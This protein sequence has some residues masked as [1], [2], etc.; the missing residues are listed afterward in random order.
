[1]IKKKNSR[2]V[3]AEIISQWLVDRRFPDRQ[4]AKVEHD[5]A[6]I[7]EVVN[8]VVRN[9]NILQWLEQGMVPKEPEPFFK[10]VLY[11]GLYQLLFMDN[12]EEYAA[13]N[14]TVDAAKGRPGGHGN[15]NMVNAVLR[16]AQR[17]EEQIFH[18][19]KRQPDDIRLSHPDFLLERWRRQFG[20]IETRKLAEWNNRPSKTILRVEQAV[21]SSAE[22]LAK[23]SEAGIELEPH[24]FSDREKFYILPR[25]LAVH[26]L[27]GYAEGW[28][29]VQDPATSVSIDLLRP[30]PGESVLDACAAPGGKTAMIASRMKGEGEL[31]ALDVHDDRI[32]VLKES[33]ER[34]GLDWVEI[35]QGD[36]RKPKDVLDG[37][38][39]DAILLDVPCLNTGVLRRRTDARWRVNTNRIK[40]I[41][42]IQYDILSACAE[43]LKENGRIVYSTCSLEPEEN[44][45]LVARWV[46]EHPGFIKVKAKKAFPPKTDTDGAFAAVIRKD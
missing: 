36:A 31:V 35:V 6:F 3:A 19:L 4:L 42:E 12:V 39:F 11:V 28:F 38:K 18:E 5:N 10:A 41:T 2:L 8:G 23:M 25:G 17:E 20:E 43:L 46:R 33:M 45:D 16:R 21:I 29:S 30:F 24:S 22:F 40:A 9:R 26:K 7:M 44:E 14:E 27:P 13:I 34:L 15:A 1:M 32:A 37:R